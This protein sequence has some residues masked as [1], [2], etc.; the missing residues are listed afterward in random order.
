MKRMIYIILFVVTLIWIPWNYINGANPEERER[1]YRLCYTQKSQEW[2]ETQGKL[3]KI[4]VQNNPQNERAWYYYFFANRYKTLGTD[5]GKREQVLASIISEMGKSISESYIYYYIRF[6]NGTGDFSDLQKSYEINPDDPDLYWEFMRHYDDLGNWEERKKFCKKLYESK[7]MASGLLEY[8]YN[9][10]NSTEKNAILFTNGD[11]DTYP[12]WVLQDVKGIREDVLDLNAHHVFVD[13]EYLKIQLKNSNIELDFDNMS[14]ENTNLF[15]KDFVS[16]M[17]TNY[18]DIPIHFALTMYTEY[19][20]SIKTNLYNVGLTL[21]YYTTPID[22]IQSLKNN[23]EN[24]FRLEYLD[25]DWYDD[26]HVSANDL[27]RFNLNYVDLF[28][29]LG[30]YYYTNGNKNFA[31]KWKS[32]ALLLAEKAN[33][34]EKINRINKLVW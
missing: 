20:D 18:P 22:T 9:V 32:K 2:Y 23:I 31:N 29:K 7:D 19:Y 12:V 16:A 21:K 17:S 1:V 25:Y 28:L 30:K 26:L 13:R 34:E 6:Y 4:E 11:N 8:N 10:L 14:H 15:L 5:Q 27:N 24:N 33:N 3:W